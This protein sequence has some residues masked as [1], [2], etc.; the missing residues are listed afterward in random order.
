MRKLIAIM[1]CHANR[2][3][4]EAQ[5]AT[6][7]KDVRE[8]NSDTDVVFFL[9]QPPISSSFALQDEVFLY[10]V[11]DTY[12]GIPEKVRR[13][14]KWATEQRY[15]YVAKCDDDVYIAPIR[16][17]H[18]PLGQSY[19]GRFRGPHGNYPAHFASGFFYW[20]DAAAARIVSTTPD[21]SDWMDERFVANSLALHRIYGY[22]DPVNY[23]V[24]GPSMCAEIAS[25]RPMFKNG[26]VFCEYRANQMED[27]HKF[28]REA[29]PVANHP[30]LRQLPQVDITAEQ[31]AVKPVDKPPQHKVERFMR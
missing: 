15:D 16:F 29:Q 23:M 22:N 4:A 10:R 11:D 17:A 7:V 5:R 20:L 18:L 3:K 13:I 12:Y 24:C 2:A 26:T 21:N 9:G 19:I 14:C 31:F 25:T 1:T 30:G 8:Q 28:F 6:W 27:M